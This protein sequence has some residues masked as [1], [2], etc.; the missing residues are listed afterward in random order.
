MTPT[1]AGKGCSSVLLSED[2]R[3]LWIV[4]TSPG[5]MT[6]V[7]GGCLY[8]TLSLKEIQG[9][10]NLWPQSH[11]FPE[12]LAQSLLFLSLKQF[13]SLPSNSDFGFLFSRVAVAK[14]TGAAKPH[15]TISKVSNGFSCSAL[16]LQSLK[17]LKSQ[18]I[19]SLFSGNAKSSNFLLLKMW[20]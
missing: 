12:H 10:G 14:T 7:E 5:R 8:P 20:A 3:G 18:A 1:A 19:S 13:H 17:P 16:V 11:D 2:S 15:T 4:A 9:L 6:C